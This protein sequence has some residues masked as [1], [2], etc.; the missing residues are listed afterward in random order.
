[1]PSFQFFSPERSSAPRSQTGIAAVPF[2]QLALLCITF[3]CCGCNLSSSPTPDISPP[4]PPA[5]WIKLQTGIDAQGPK[6]DVGYRGEKPTP[7]QDFEAVV[8]IARD[9]QAVTDAMVFCQLVSAAG[10]EPYSDEVAT[11]YESSSGSAALYSAKLKV[12]AEKPAAAA[13]RVRVIFADREESWSQLVT[14][15]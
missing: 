15:P 14:I 9:G 13:L 4:P 7:K 1:M 3:L 10:E 8:A 2:F 12:S 5:A 6:I 11:I